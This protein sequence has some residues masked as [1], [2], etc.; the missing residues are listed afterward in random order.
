MTFLRQ[1]TPVGPVSSLGI[2]PYPKRS[3]IS[4]RPDA[5]LWACI[6]VCKRK[7]QK[8]WTSRTFGLDSEILVLRFFGKIYVV[9]VKTVRS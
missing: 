7:R 6:R 9:K 5:R 8:G 4:H 3:R 1:W 2:F